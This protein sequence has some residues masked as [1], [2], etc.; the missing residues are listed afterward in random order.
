MKNNGFMMLFGPQTVFLA[1]NFFQMTEKTTNLLEQK[2]TER[3]KIPKK[4]S[5]ADLPKAFREALHISSDIKSISDVVEQ[6]TIIQEALKDIVPEY[7]QEEI[8]ENERWYVPRVLLEKRNTRIILL[9]RAGLKTKTILDIIN[10]RAIVEKWWMIENVRAVNKIKEKF[11]QSPRPL[12]YESN[13]EKKLVEGWIYKQQEI[14]EKF[15]LAMPDAPREDNDKSIRRWAEAQGK[16]IQIH[17]MLINN[18][19]RNRSRFYKAS[20]KRM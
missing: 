19:W 7:D 15:S 4:V 16:L 5:I 13:E 17:Q 18:Q 2:K 3:R 11:N 12:S 14:I 8:I 6:D 9:S 20:H 1:F 10:K